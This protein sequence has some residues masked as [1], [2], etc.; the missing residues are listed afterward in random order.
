MRTIGGLRRWIG[1]LPRARTR[2]PVDKNAPNADIDAR[3][4]R[5]TIS[6]DASIK[7]KRRTIMLYIAENLKS[8]RKSRDFTQ[9]E[10]ATALSISPQS[11]SKWE[12]GDT[13]PDITMLPALANLFH[14]SVDELIGM[15]KINDANA[16]NSVYTRA[17]DLIRNLEYARAC[18][19]Y[20]NALKSFPNDGGLMSDLA[21]ALALD[22]EQQRL[23]R[24]VELC[25]RVLANAAS[26]KVQ[27][28]T[29]AALCFIYLKCGERERAT[30][31]AQNLPHARES[32]EHVLSEFERIER[33]GDTEFIEPYLRYIALG[34]DSWQDISIVA[35]GVNLVPMATE[36]D[37]VSRLK[38]LREK[39][40]DRIMPPVRVK[41]EPLYAPN[42]V[43]VRSYADKLLDAEFSSPAEA[44]DAVVAAFA[45][46]GE[47]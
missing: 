38:I 41:D 10:I 6:T 23:H 34:D 8:L 40:G 4:K 1:N 33:D 16:R 37:I 35:F 31:T 32:R 11:V 3:R 20:E 19:L 30:A 42:R 43:T 21:M 25:E 44:A 12:R 36:F 45:R 14:T 47:T 46:L 2:L 22:G 27:H 29:R 5:V 26:G 18:E 13:Y 28:T 15:A 17:H 24:A 9:E 39:L 7:L